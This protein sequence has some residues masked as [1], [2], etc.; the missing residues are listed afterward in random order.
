MS[1]P[2]RVSIFDTFGL[3]KVF[4]CGCEITPPVVH[5][6]NNHLRNF[7]H[8]RRQFDNNN[9]NNND[10]HHPAFLKIGGGVNKDN[11]VSCHN[12]N[13]MNDYI[14]STKDFSSSSSEDSSCS[15][16]DKQCQVS[17]TNNKLRQKFER[18]AQQQQ[19]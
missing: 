10:H 4:H 1:S 19:Q 18:R 2:D 5:F 16:D 14:R 11:S 7:R 13:I 12:N 17:S 15:N 8:L 9:N 3:K 6:D